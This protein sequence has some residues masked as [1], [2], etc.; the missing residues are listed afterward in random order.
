VSAELEELAQADAIAELAAKSGVDIL[1]LS[2]GV[3]TVDRR[4]IYP[5]SIGLPM[6]YLPSGLQFA[7]RHQHFVV[8]VSGNLTDTRGVADIPGNVLLGVARALIADPDFANKSS[9]GDHDAIHRCARTNRCHYFSRRRP[10]LECG[11]NRSVK[12]EGVKA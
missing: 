10:S 11:V 7:L 12:A 9:R 4:R 5:G 6:P 2:A 8:T 1:D 3:Y